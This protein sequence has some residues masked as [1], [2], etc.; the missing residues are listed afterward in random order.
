MNFVRPGGEQGVRDANQQQLGHAPLHKGIQPQGQTSPL[1]P[2][3]GAA[4]PR[5]QPSVG[6]IKPI[7]SLFLRVSLGSRR[8]DII[9]DGGATVSFMTRQLAL[10]LN[11]P[12]KPN[13]ELARLADKRYRIQSQG[14]VDFCVVEVST[15][16]A[17]RV[18]ALVMEHLAVDCYGGTTFQYDNYIVPDIVTS[19]VYMHGFKYSVCLPPKQPYR[20]YPPPSMQPAH[21]PP[22]LNPLKPTPQ[23]S[24]SAL[25]NKQGAACPSPTPSPQSVVMKA[26]RSLLPSGTYAI[27]VSNVPKDCPVLVLLPTP[28]PLD[29]FKQQF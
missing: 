23:L 7:P 3:L 15:R 28:S 18:R 5:V 9:L 24:A 16:V 14:E 10:S 27:P 22:A 20:A 1:C 8:F 12:I 25:I 19:T 6:S 21:K 26:S 4:N 11:L 17:L 13:G 2:T 29:S